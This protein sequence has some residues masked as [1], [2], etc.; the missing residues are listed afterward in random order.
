MFNEL[1]TLDTKQ[2]NMNYIR[3]SISIAFSHKK[4][5]RAALPQTIQTIMVDEMF[6]KSYAI[7]FMLDNPTISV[8]I[9]HVYLEFK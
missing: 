5:N 6:S 2:N 1:I 3:K 8:W 9:W 7:D 4:K